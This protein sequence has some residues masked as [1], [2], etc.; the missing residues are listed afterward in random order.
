MQR[1]ESGLV[2]SPTDLTKFLA[3]QHITTLDLAVADGGRGKP[4]VP[5]D[6]L[7]QLLFKKG[8]EHET[9]VL[10]TMQLDRDVEIIDAPL[11]AAVAATEAAMARG[12]EVIYQAAFL[13]DGRRGHAD[14]L[15][16][17]DRP[18]RLGNWS[19]DVADTKLARR[20][21]VP[22]LLQMAAYGEHLRRIQGDPPRTLTVIAGD[23]VEHVVAFA[24]VE[25]YARR[26]TARFDEFVRERPPTIA[27]PVPHC[28][29]CRWRIECTRGWREVDHL[30]FVAFLPRTQRHKLEKAGITT[31]AELAAQQPAGL[32]RA[33]GRPA[34]ERLVSQARLQLA[35]R[36]AH[37]P[38]YELLD[39]VEGKGL[40]RL[41]EPDP[42]DLYLDFEADRYVEP[43]G[44]E[45][46]AGLGDRDDEFTPIWAHSFDEERALTET[47]I[48]HIL[49]RWR[50]HPG[51]H[52]Y[53]YAP[54]EKAALQ[55]L[56]ARHGIR[57][58]ELD[59]LL[60]AGVLVDLYAVVRQ[61]L[62]I[63]KESYSIKKL[64]AFYWGHVRGEGDGD[65][66][67]AE[68]ISSVLAYERWLLE[69]DEEILK[70]IAAYNF[71]DVRST[72]DL[73]DWLEERRVE[74]EAQH[75]R[76][77]QRPGPPERPPDPGPAELA[78][79]ELRT[80]MPGRRP[81]PARRLGRLASP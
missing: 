46:L 42:A 1:D 23:A 26:V 15:C 76:T 64:E 78:E 12:A 32:P 11:V 65:G 75:G 53:H 79:A 51:M 56:T 28:D 57:E 74:L 43:D 5:T 72:H 6:E 39:P 8:I 63:S 2:V 21:K 40:L 81:P 36:D 7:L 80:T 10:E 48:D 38:S 22:A 49:D 58:A 25:A 30:S 3:C 33:I 29:Q 59:I 77:F 66:G 34:R 68:A 55:R 18:S 67:V 37:E 17:A 24:D 44:L 9:R 61:G 60:R 52:V 54:Y 14:F 41:P 35:E 70:D 69:Q 13:H 27:D 20:L 50:G 73:H 4:W 45:Y 31:L 16:R 47:L 71:D 62:R 19:Y